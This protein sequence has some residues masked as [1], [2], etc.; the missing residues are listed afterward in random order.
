LS[1]LPDGAFLRPDLGDRRLRVDTVVLDV[2]GVLVDV[3]ASFRECVR[4][5]AAA[6]QRLMGVAE[7]WTPSVQDITLFKR[8]GGFNDDIELSIAMTA[9]GAAG[10]GADVAAIAAAAEAAGG[11]LRALRRVAPDLPR[12]EGRLVLRVFEERYYGAEEYER[13]FADQARYAEPGPGLAEEERALVGADFIDRLR[14]GGARCVALITGR[15]PTELGVALRRLDW[16]SDHVDATVTGDMVRKPDPEC[17]DRVLASCAGGAAVYVGDVRDDWE[18]VR[19]YRAERPGGAAVYGV[20]V[21]D[22]AEM[23]RY[24]A[25]G[26][27][28]TLRSTEDLIALLLRWSG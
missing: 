26:V 28:A 22:D 9:I 17:L 19:R 16:T 18:L 11:G 7:P 10:R 25:L 20:L 2:D 3:H 13:L 27:D 6:V 8:A 12:I 23:L 21:G 5:T 24:R 15:N 4:G 1:D 14:R